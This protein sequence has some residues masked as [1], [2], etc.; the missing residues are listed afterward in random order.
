VEI[1]EREGSA[2][3]PPR[4]RQHP[5]EHG[6]ALGRRAGTLEAEPRPI[7]ADRTG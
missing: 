6:R 5:P 2:L 4:P 7:A 3:S 1:L